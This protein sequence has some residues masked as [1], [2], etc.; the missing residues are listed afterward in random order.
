MSFHS[1]Q[2][3][4]YV[5]FW[6]LDIVADILYVIDIYIRTR[7]SYMF[8]GCLITDPKQLVKNYCVD[9]KFKFV[10]DIAA[11][12]PLDHIV[13]NLVVMPVICQEFLPAA[14]RLNRCLKFDRLSEFLDR[15]ET[16]TSFPNVFRITILCCFIL[17]IVHINACL[18]FGFSRFIGI[19]SD[20]WVYP[21]K[22]TGWEN[23]TSVY[24]NLS[25]QYIFS[26]YWSTLTLTA[27]GEYTGPTSNI[28]YMFQ[29]LDFLTGVL[30]FA[31][32]VGNVGTMIAQANAQKTNFQSK[33][34]S[35]KQYMRLRKVSADLQIRV[36]KWFD[37]LWREGKTIDEEA[38]LNLLPAK[39]RA[40][41]A[42][43]VHLDT[44]K[45]VKLFQ[46]TEPGFLL[47]LVLKLKPQVYSPL[48]FVCKKGD[49]GREMYIVKEGELEVVSEDL[50]KRFC[51]LKAGS[52]MGELSILDIPGRTS[53]NRRTAH[54]RA[55]GY[56]DLFALSGED[57]NS[58][59]NDYPE[60]KNLITERGQSILRKDNL[61]DEALIEK[62]KLKQKLD[63]T[64]MAMNIEKM[65]HCIVNLQEQMLGL[66]SGLDLILNEMRAQ[67]A[68]QIL[69]RMGVESTRNI[70]R[71]NR[72][73]G[74]NLRRRRAEKDDKTR[75]SQ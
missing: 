7:T 61:L 39:L 60:A 6:H 30:I 68:R 47:A 58:V 25:R 52:Y 49:I 27:I 8:N 19:K 43:N 22:G 66:S 69:P 1:L 5:L 17:V 70:T 63:P 59:M 23:T 18:W 28:E 9:N 65:G 50:S 56:C 12:F 32:I 16:R 3:D 45:N 75:K 31:T 40:D 55:I 37:Y 33:V 62:E 15:V 13:N 46:D 67:H 74:E 48:D 10:L 34:D 36:I 57:L 26:L 35:I 38:V 29:L 11:V 2:T 24:E 21:P 14:L 53:G 73:N 51:V 44:L 42:L 64:E 20:N 4:Y 41:V 72:S 54:V 71:R